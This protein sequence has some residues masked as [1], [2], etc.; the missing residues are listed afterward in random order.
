MVGCRRLGRVGY[1]C[2]VLRYKEGG[3]MFAG[4]SKKVELLLQCSALTGEQE[5]TV[6]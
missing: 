2:T 5:V 1:H 6:Y 3:K 4:S